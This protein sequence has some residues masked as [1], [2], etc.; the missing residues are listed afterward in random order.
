MYENESRKQKGEAERRP[1]AFLLLFKSKRPVYLTVTDAPLTDIWYKNQAMSNTMKKKRP[2]KQNCAQKIIRNHSARKTTAG[3]LKSFR[4]PKC[5]IKNITCHISERGR[6]A[7]DSG[8]EDEMFS[9]SPAIS[10]F[11]YCTW[12]VVQKTFKPS[13]SPVQSKLD[14]SKTLHP[15]PVDNNKFS[16]GIN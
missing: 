7:Y 13:P 5:E 9:M 2:Q 11:K 15:A 8:N 6:D 10:K 16:F 14:F 1:V 12:T 3:N 4:F